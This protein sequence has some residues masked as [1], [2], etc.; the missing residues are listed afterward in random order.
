MVNKGVRGRAR[1]YGRWRGRSGG[2][3]R[4]GGRG[5]DWVGE[6]VIGS[7]E[8]EREIEDEEEI[9]KRRACRKGE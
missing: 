5:N 9:E 7:S 6:G 3:G 4:G 1:R 2:G 8:L